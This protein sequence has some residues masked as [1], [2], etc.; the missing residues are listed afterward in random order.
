MRKL[1]ELKISPIFIFVYIFIHY[2]KI[3]SLNT[4]VIYR[5]N[6]VII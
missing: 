2:N 5:K 1:T 3:K 6:A 4:K